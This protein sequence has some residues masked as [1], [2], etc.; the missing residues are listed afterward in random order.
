MDVF[1]ELTEL[2]VI[3]PNKD[4]YAALVGDDKPY[5]TNQDL[6]RA[7]AEKEAFIERLK[8]EKKQVLDDLASRMKL[9][10]IATL[11]DKASET[12]SQPLPNHGGEPSQ[13]APALTQEDIERF[14]ENKMQR[15]TETKTKTSN[16]SQVQEKLQSLYGP[17]FA[18]IVQQ[19]ASELG[20]GTDFLTDLA[21]K[22]PKAF[23][24]LL[25]VEDR[26]PQRDMFAPP[27]TVF[28]PS[29]VNTG[30]TWSYYEKLRKDKPTEYYSPKVQNDMM[31]QLN[32]LGQEAF[33]K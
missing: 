6:A 16:L 31:K 11:I 21:A 4:Y 26:Q 14:I 20:V 7:T 9:E 23:Y 27:S 12:R 8:L 15:D 32:E 28:V 24:R 33:Y 30:Q 18:T 3:D 19:K 22:Q 13:S 5:K 2:P 29:T 1:K 17:N 10:E 25:G